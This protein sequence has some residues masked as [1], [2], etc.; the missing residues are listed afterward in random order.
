MK[1]KKADSHDA[2]LLF[3]WANDKEVREMAFS[4]EPIEWGAHEKWFTDKLAD[5]SCTIYIGVNKR[6][7]P[8]GQVRFDLLSTGEA[9]IDIHTNPKLRGKGGGSELLAL[10]LNHYLADKRLTAIHAWIKIDNIKS[11]RLFSRLGFVQREKKTIQ[12]TLCYHMVKR[13]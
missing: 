11:F 1:L 8:V 4:S 6:N 9:E 7:E 12:Q 13:T 10:A 5:K 2:S 3:A